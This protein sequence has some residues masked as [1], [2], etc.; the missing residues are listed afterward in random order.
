MKKLTLWSI[1]TSAAQGNHA[2]AER[3]VT[4]ATAQDWLKVFRADEPKV[5]FLVSAR[6][7]KV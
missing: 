7:P 2:K 4:E 1:R 6:K 5:L 3:E